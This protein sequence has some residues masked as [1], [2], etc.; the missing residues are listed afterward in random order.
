MP[1]HFQ[2]ALVYSQLGALDQAIRH[3]E[4]AVRLRPTVPG[5][6]FDLAGAYRSAGDVARAVAEY[7]EVLVL[8]PEHVAARQVLESLE[9]VN[10]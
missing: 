1:A 3:F 9:G 2:L 8:D 6:R 4:E 5:Y 10:R 7:R